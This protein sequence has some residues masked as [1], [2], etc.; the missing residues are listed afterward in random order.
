[1]FSLG[2]QI[3]ATFTYKPN[4]NRPLTILASSHGALPTTN[5]NT[6]PRITIFVLI[7]N[8]HLI[9]KITNSVQDAEMMSL[10]TSSLLYTIKKND[11]CLTAC[12]PALFCSYQIILMLSV[13]YYRTD[14]L[15]MKWHIWTMDFNK[16]LC[17]RDQLLTHSFTPCR[18][19]W[20]LF[21]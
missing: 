3:T 18:N 16:V 15:Y 21:P 1:M 19:C 13:I 9:L 11:T 5:H 8:R 7:T 4:W 6:D 17:K 12:V 10:L 2:L 14:A 20:D